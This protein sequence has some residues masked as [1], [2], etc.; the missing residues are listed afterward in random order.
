MSGVCVSYCKHPLGILRISGP[1]LS[2]REKAQAEHGMQNTE[3]P[4]FR[5]VAASR[6][7][8]VQST[9]CSGTKSQTV[10]EDAVFADESVIGGDRGNEATLRPADA[11]I[12]EERAE[13][14]QHKVINIEK[15]V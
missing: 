13:C 10:L 11:K 15:P 8:T 9:E 3:L 2:L 1:K 7:G 14:I 4:P 5:T 12:S 6:E